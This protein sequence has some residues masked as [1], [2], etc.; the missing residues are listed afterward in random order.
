MFNADRHANSLTF[1][2]SGGGKRRRLTTV[3][4]LPATDG[5][6]EPGM[7]VATAL[8]GRLAGRGGPVRAAAASGG[9]A[10]GAAPAGS[11]LRWAR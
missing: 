3:R 2:G 9:W 5:L 1:R 10:I 8:M 4:F 11:A 6:P 7:W